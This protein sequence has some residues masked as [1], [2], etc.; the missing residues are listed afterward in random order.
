MTTQI[1]YLSEYQFLGELEPFKSKGLP[2]DSIIQKEITGCGATTLELYFDRNSII[3]EPNL[4]VILGKAKKLNKNRRKNKLVL[5]VHDSVTVDDIK[6]HI[7]KCTGNKKILT[8][9]E[10]FEKVINALGD[11]ALKEYFLL[12]DECEKAIQDISYRD[13]IISPM[14]LFFSFKDKAFVSATPIIPSD[15]RFQ[16]FEHVIIKPDYTYKHQIKV[17]PTNNIIFQLK[18]IFDSYHEYGQPTSRKFFI[19]FKSTLR[20]KHIVQGLELTDHSIYCSETSVKDLK[21]NSISNVYDRVN[22][23]FSNYNFFTSRFFS[24]VDFDYT[25]YNCNPIIIMISDPLAIEHT[26][27]DPETEAI[28]IIGRFR[29]PERVDGQPRIKV[30]KDIYHI[31]NYKSTLTSYTSNEIDLILNDISKVQ[32]WLL[33]FKGISDSKYFNGF[34]KDI[35]KVK[36]FAYYYKTGK[37]NYFMFDNF[38]NAEIVKGYYKTGNGV[39]KKYQQM[40]RFTVDI[41]SQYNNHILTDADLR[42]IT[43]QTAT[44]KV[45]AFVSLRVKELMGNTMDIAYRDFNMNMLRIIYQKQMAIFDKFTMVKAAT[46]DYDIDSI[47][48]HELNVLTNVDVDLLTTYVRN[49]YNPDGLTSG[50]VKQILNDGFKATGTKGYTANIATLRLIAELSKRDNVKKDSQGKWQKGYKII[51][52]YNDK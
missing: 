45:N 22:S 31:T 35:F 3:I 20:I 46:F 27:I 9:P 26:V 42:E 28:Q 13:R 51:R 44:S 36:Q 32:Q 47:E 5:A 24:A 43:N 41:T 15:P 16:D 52:F 38:K 48:K 39:I 37:P 19:F 21:K 34:R 7:D 6:A 2:G 30:I 25:D 40:E 50:E 49:N 11:T 23:N 10:G 14:D 18:K 12:F 17:Y 1:H 29:E 33:N 8:T 4:P